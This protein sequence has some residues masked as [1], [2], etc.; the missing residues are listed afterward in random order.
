MLQTHAT[1]PSILNYLLGFNLSHPTSPHT[2]QHVQN[3]GH[4][5]HD[6]AVIHPDPGGPSEASLSPALIRHPSP[7]LDE[8]MCQ[9]S[10]R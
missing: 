6:D 9:R 10:R 2:L 3:K 1:S 8:A 7:A 5:N 4:L